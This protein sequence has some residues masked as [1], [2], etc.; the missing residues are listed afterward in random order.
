M[1]E[2]ETPARRMHGH[3]PAILP[4]GKSHHYSRIQSASATTR[5]VRWEGRHRIKCHNC[6]AAQL[7]LSVLHELGVVTSPGSIHLLPRPRPRPPLPTLRPCPVP[8]ARGTCLTLSTRALVVHTC[9]RGISG[10]PL[11]ARGA[12]SSPPAS[13][14]PVDSSTSS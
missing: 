1:T 13:A 2:I 7:S 12:S 4:P 3:L 10:L 5:C 14:S 11:L 9:Y 8:C 6:S